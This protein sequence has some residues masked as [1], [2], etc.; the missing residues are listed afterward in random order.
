MVDGNG[1][2]ERGHVLFLWSPSGYRLSERDGEPPAVGTE[3]TD[4]GNG[5]VVTKVGPSPLPGDSRP[6]AFTTGRR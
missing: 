3:L 5:L 6:C 1:H 2:S 4:E